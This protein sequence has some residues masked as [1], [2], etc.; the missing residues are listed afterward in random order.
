MIKKLFAVCL[1]AALALS[2]AGA[3]SGALAVIERND[4]RAWRV[5]LQR[6]DGENIVTRLENSPE[7]RLFKIS[8]I[9][10]LDFLSAAYD[11]AAA[12]ARFRA[13]DYTEAIRI[14]APSIMPYQNFASISNNL[15]AAFCL[16]V[17]AYIENGDF[18][19]ARDLSACLISSHNPSVQ[20]SAQV[21]RALAALG[22]GDIPTAEAIMPK[23]QNS[24][25]K[26]YVQACVER[27]KKQPKAAIQTAIK[28]IAEYPNDMGWMPQTELL[29]AELYYEMGM[30]NSA[31]ATARQT[32]KLYA[33][34]NVEKEALALRSKIEPSTAKPE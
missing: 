27:A 14:M 4:G 8:D 23:I 31:V 6:I 33:G 34:T 7:D 26:L 15:E 22:G 3:S 25:A 10:R 29:C 1:P 21:G 18:A 19:Q 20:V 24:A 17:N 13:A 11:S 5:Y 28:L 9:V 2:A 30:T 32:Q 12:E 16:L